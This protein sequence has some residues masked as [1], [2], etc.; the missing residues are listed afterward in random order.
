[1]GK[2]YDHGLG[3]GGNIIDL[4]LLLYPESDLQSVLSRFNQFGQ[5]KRSSLP[6]TTLSIETEFKPK[7]YQI[8][9]II[10]LGNNANL[11]AYLSSR[12]INTQ[13]NKLLK[14]V[15][16]CLKTNKGTIKDYYAIGWQNE[17]GGWEIRNK[18]FIHFI[19]SAQ[20]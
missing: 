20:I 11:N 2:W 13:S 19:V 12:G 15:Y 18:F 1:M 4:A 10:E 14:E 6:V 9:A 5:F 16:Y 17:A 8:T 3:T 7:S